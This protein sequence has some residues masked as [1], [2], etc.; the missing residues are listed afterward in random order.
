[1]ANFIQI[2]FQ[3][4]K[5]EV[6][7]FLK[8]E[9]NKSDVLYSE[10]S[11]YG[12]ILSVLENLQQLSF[13]YLKNAI[14][15]FDLSNPNST[16]PRIIRNAAIYAGHIPGRGISATGT[17]KFTLKSNADTNTDIPGQRL[18]FTNKQQLKNKT[19]GLN[20]SINIG[21]ET[22]TF[23]ISPGTQFFIPIIQGS[24]KQ[25]IFTGTGEVNQT[26]Q[27]ALSGQQDVENF[28]VQILVNGEYW[29]I[30]KHI[31][32]LLPDENSCVVR[33]GFN[34]G[35]DIIFGNSGFGNIPPIG[36]VIEANYL[37]TDGANGNIFRRT[38]NDW[39]FVDEVIDGFGNSLDITKT[40]D[41]QI[42]TDINFGANQENLLF[43][44]SILPIVSNNFVLGLPQQY[45]YQ[46]K[47]LGVFS[48]VNAYETD[49]TV[50]IVC[51]PNIQ[52]FK[53]QNGDYFT[54]KEEAFELDDYEKSKIDKYLKGGG[55]IQLSRKYKI[56]SPELSRYIVN[57]FIIIYSDA[58]P[59][60]VNAQILDKISNY[61]LNFNRLDRI[62]KSD[63]VYQI[64]SLNDVHSVDVQFISQKNENYHAQNKVYQQNQIDALNSQ[65][66]NSIAT[67]IPDP[68]YVATTTL[69]LDP[70]L[71][72]I[73]FEPSE[74][75]IIRG[76][77][78]DRSGIFYSDNINSKGLK[79]VNIFVQRVV[80]AKLRNNF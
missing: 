35:I 26:Y 64:S 69:G 17:L 63:L 34:G 3:N 39:T 42:Y 2:S 62:P 51:T 79:S 59:D 11:P 15:Q 16:N 1:M 9:H 48:H 55:N 68:N 23:K 73:L 20:Y 57:I 43:T 18:T 58:T 75:P 80:D 72:D 32:E 14:N 21:S 44:K 74:I 31:Y 38:I 52:L 53:N 49:G 46:I 40:F 25:T 10:A 60:S 29:T 19:N 67:F 65:T 4:I 30:K 8:I 24:F 28:N 66:G 6:E 41:V 77:W 45:A 50:M 47:K 13:L 70:K 33:T 12:Q 56:T 27:V 36:A 37:V 71:G 22:M 76:G 7:R 54:I 5:S 61:F 78:K